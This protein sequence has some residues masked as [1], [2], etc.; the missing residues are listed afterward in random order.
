M[1][2]TSEKNVRSGLLITTYLKLAD[3][4]KLTLAEQ[5]GILGL[6]ENSGTYTSWRN[7]PSSAI[8]DKDKLT[9]LT[10]ILAIY[11]ELQVKFPQ[12]EAMRNWLRSAIAEKPFNGSTPLAL[13]T[14]GEIAKSVLVRQYLT[15]PS[16]EKS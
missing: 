8:L 3:L 1:A 6:A 9:K 10:L 11:K 2:I 15:T 4:W 13:L 7:I 14:S 5:T 16:S 12:E